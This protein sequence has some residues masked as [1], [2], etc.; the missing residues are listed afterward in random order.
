MCY[1]MYKVVTYKNIIQSNL[2]NSKHNEEQKSSNYGELLSKF[3]SKSGL[4]NENSTFRSF[5]H[6]SAINFSG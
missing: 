1:I 2:G 6:G 5:V 3:S 4:T